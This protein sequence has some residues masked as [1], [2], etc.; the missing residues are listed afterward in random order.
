MYENA[1]EYAGIK[2]PPVLV[3]KQT[4]CGSLY[5]FMRL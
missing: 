3:T 2:K 5:E 4:A 1:G